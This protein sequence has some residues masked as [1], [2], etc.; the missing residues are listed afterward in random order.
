VKF[1]C[2][3]PDLI[4]ALNI[5]SK[6]ITSRT[7]IPVLKGILLTAGEDDALQLSASDLNISV[8]TTMDA[9]VASAGSLIIQAKLFSDIIRKFPSGD[10]EI[11]EKENGVVHIKCMR[12][13]FTLMSV[14]PDEFPGIQD[15]SDGERISFDRDILKEMIRKTCFA[16]SIEEI[17]GIFTGVL[18]EVK[19]DSLTMVA[20]DGFRMAVVREKT[21]SEEKR[22]IIIDA[23]LMAD[24]GRIIADTESGERRGNKEKETPEEDAKDAA[25]TAK[26]EAGA[27][28]EK[29]GEESSVFV[30]LDDKKA[31]FH[32][33]KTRVF[34]RILEGE[35]IKYKDILPKE[36]AT[37]V[38]VNKNDIQE[39][40]ERASLLIREGKN[41]FIKCVISDDTLCIV[42]RTEEGAVREEVSIDKTGEDL[43]IGFNAKF[44]LDALK[45][46][47]DE[48]IRMEFNTAT[49]PCLIKP[50]E[51]D[52]FEYMV[53]PVRLS[54][55]N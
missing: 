29:E 6:A 40:V 42:S 24:V 30:E 1:S 34:V 2:K 14:P 21:E 18:M 33:K 5:V 53:L 3:Q 54:A 45:A 39:S 8:E 15:I 44:I 11:E 27:R 23:R 17:R 51:G 52:S 19:E 47:S 36:C 9:A 50:M 41:H 16:A 25:K 10:V 4:Q 38:I 22:N 12:S 26:K 13:E 48:D 7:T 28:T 55:G 35:F 43:S 32:L 31:I 37:S 49:A 46:I 20:L